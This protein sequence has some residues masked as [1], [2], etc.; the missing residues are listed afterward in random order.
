MADHAIHNERTK[1]TANYLNGLAT[2]IA[3]AGAFAPLFA[4]IYRDQDVPSLWIIGLGFCVCILV[5]VTL[6][7]FAR[8]MLGRIRT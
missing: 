3:A 1:L 2:A 8:W 4:L 6:H 5:S 7:S